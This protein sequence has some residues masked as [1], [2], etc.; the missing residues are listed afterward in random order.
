MAE[1]LKIVQRLQQIT[2]DYAVFERDQVLTAGQLNSI[3]EYLDDQGRLT[4]TRLLGIGI[5]GGLYPALERRAVVVSAGVGVTSDGDLIA[6][7]TPTTYNRWVDY[8]EHAPAYLPFYVDGRRVPLR[9]LLTSD[10]PRTGRDLADIAS[11]L[12][13][14]VVVAFMESYENDPDLCT[15]SDCDNRGRTA[16]NRQR[17]LL[18]ERKFAENLRASAVANGAA[19][20][21]QLPRLRAV[22]AD[23]G[24][25]QDSRVD[26]TSAERFAA[27]YRNAA[28]RTLEALREA[29]LPLPGLLASAGIGGLP[30]PAGW[31]ALLARR[32]ES[33]AATVAGV[34]YVQAHAKDLVAVWNELRA[35]LRAD[36]GVLAPA[37]G[38]FAKHLLLGALA[39]PAQ[40]RSGCH[41]APWLIDDGVARRRVLRLMRLFDALLRNFEMPR[42]QIPK[43][44]PSRREGQPLGARAIPIYYRD[45]VGLRQLW[46]DEALDH[47][48][49]NGYHWMPTPAQ[50][51]ADDPFNEDQG[52]VDFYRIEGLLGL[53]ADVA[54]KAIS[55]LVRQRNLPIG[56]IAV[57]AHNERR[58]IISPPKFRRTD[59]HSLHYLL[60]Q[61][62]VG[63]LRDTTTYSNW[64]IDD[65][66]AAGSSL[67]GVGGSALNK[68]F[69]RP[70]EAA[71][72]GL[73]AA[74]R[75]L[76]GDGSAPG[77]LLARSY[78][79]FNPVDNAAFTRISEVMTGTARARA[80]IGEI[81]RNDVSSPIDSFVGGK[82]HLWAG[83]LGDILK[84]RDE[85][86]AERLLLPT[87]LNEHPGLE[88]GG[89]VTPGG[90]FFLVY[91]DSGLVIGDLMLPYWI[92]DNDEA[93]LEEPELK[94]PDI[95][96][97]L[98]RDVLPIK[99]IKPLE[100]TLEDFRVSRI[101]PEIRIQESYATFFQSSLGSLS[102]VIKNTGKGLAVDDR[103]GG[104]RAASDDGYLSAMLARI[105]AE[106]QQL[107]GMK[108][109]EGNQT[110]P[111]EVRQRASGQA[112]EIEARL[113]GTISETARYFAV[114]ADESVRFGADKTVVYATLG[115]AA[116]EIKDDAASN[117]LKQGVEATAA[118]A[119]N[120]AGGSS[121]LVAGQMMNNAFRFR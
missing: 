37:P 40:L 97:R 74:S 59:L 62:L 36:A 10:D 70:L 115:G 53:K 42:A 51:A 107:Q 9:E 73:A 56:V 2:T 13:G 24:S 69:A 110:L 89:G 113:A 7:D 120:I 15:G 18:I 95:G 38:V 85:D 68:D 52:A 17:L 63:Q 6:L 114:D 66:K 11:Q 41:P 86:A 47:D 118:A 112:K 82:T 79:R 31:A 50:G 28:Q 14:M 48:R 3:T 43:I 35:A 1:P 21:A 102:E 16:R 108:A 81:A 26:V 96:L 27:R 103:V 109:V 106:K 55:R 100:R 116:A 72:D 98:P 75:E 12:P 46:H 30:S 71:R 87:V 61:D 65:V 58:W 117:S 54:E 80:E 105:E 20:A 83:W 88:H 64:L 78:R 34:Q 22:R 92:D 101:L 29:V 8:D 44:T 32:A 91:D 49:A 67:S 99:V 111:E 77:P 19:L 33:L 121:A 84:K 23:L 4:R 119:S 94:L 45:D 76:A 39:D 25:G 60:R 90:T 104:T 57:L 93:G 5:V